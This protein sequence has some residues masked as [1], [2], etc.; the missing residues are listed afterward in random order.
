MRLGN[1]EEGGLF[2]IRFGV[3]GLMASKGED[4]GEAGAHLKSTAV[5]AKEPTSRSG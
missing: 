3:S 2:S 5:S 4:R 1:W